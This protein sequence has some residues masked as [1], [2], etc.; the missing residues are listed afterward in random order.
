MKCFNV[1]CLIRAS[2]QRRH[3][4]G[5]VGPSDAPRAW[6]LWSCRARL[7]D[8]NFQSSKKE[9]IPSGGRIGL[10]PEGGTL[11]RSVRVEPPLQAERT[12]Q[13]AK[14]AVRISWNQPVLPGLVQGAF[15]VWESFFGKKV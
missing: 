1:R 11:S 10:C 5:S 6:R 9:E 8:P 15:L 3:M 2:L 12:E 14:R 13:R 7:V 4:S